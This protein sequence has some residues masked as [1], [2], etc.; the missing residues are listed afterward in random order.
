MIYRHATASA[1]VLFPTAQ[2]L[3]PL[4]WWVPWI[5]QSAVANVGLS[6]GYRPLMEEYTPREDWEEYVRVKKA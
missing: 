3:G 2:W 5:L 4:R 6:C 1:L